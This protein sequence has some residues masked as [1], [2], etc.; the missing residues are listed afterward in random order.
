M[1]AD[2][3]HQVLH[4]TPGHTSLFLGLGRIH[5]VPKRYYPVAQEQSRGWEDHIMK[6]VKR[7]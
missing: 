2:V 7:I 3:I 6:Q 5:S 1:G 4:P